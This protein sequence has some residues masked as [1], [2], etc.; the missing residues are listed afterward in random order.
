MSKEKMSCYSY[1]I[2]S[3]IKTFKIH[4]ESVDSQSDGFGVNFNVARALFEICSEIKRLDNN[5]ESLSDAYYGY[6]P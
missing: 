5:H 1:D 4:A 2:D 6:N 3:L